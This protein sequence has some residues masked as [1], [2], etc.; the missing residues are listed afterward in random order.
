M[1]T[2]RDLGSIA[3]MAA[4]R[5]DQPRLH[6]WRQLWLCA[7][8]QPFWRLTLLARNLGKIFII[9]RSM[10]LYYDYYYNVQ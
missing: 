6:C 2:G 7:Y 5:G 10:R 1:D 4:N 9:R 8:Q 3:C